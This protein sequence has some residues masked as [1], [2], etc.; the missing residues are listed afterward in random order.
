MSAKSMKV[1]DMTKGNPLRLILTFALPILIGNIFQQVYSIVDTM[2]AGY[3]LGDSAIAAIGA[4]S[5]LY[6][7]II[8]LAW[9]M[10]SGFA[11]VVTRAFGAHDEAEVRK[12]VAGT[13]MLDG[14]VTI[15]LT[16]VSLILL[17]PLMHLMNTPE[18]IFSDAY[19][20]MFIICAGMI[21]TITYNMFASLLRSFGNSVVPLYFLIF[22][23]VMNI[24]LDL[25]FV[26]PM[27]M[28]VAGAAL[29]TVISELLS[30]ILSGAYYFRNYKPMVP[31]KE[32]FRISGELFRELASNGSAMAFMY[33]VVNLGSVFFQGANNKLAETL[34]E[35]IITAHTAARRIIGIMMTPLG[36][37][38]GA[39][40]TYIGQNYGAK[41]MKRVKEGLKD[42]LFIVAGWGV[43]ACAVIYLFG[44]QL[45]RFTTGTTDAE[46][47]K[48]AM[49]SLRI[50]L[51]LYPALGVLLALRTAM[52]AVNIK[53]P[54]VV[55][56][57]IELAMKI[58]AAAWLIPK[59]GFIG[60]CITEPITWVLCAVF[61]IAVYWRKRNGLYKSAH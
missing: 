39:A 47:L 20:Y 37:V 46:V 49:M 41:E 52:Q 30:A 60:T 8:D 28:G 31:G 29:A 17:R 57:S 10:N 58:I 12:A 51:P 59:L 6:A 13:V 21:G 14:A 24:L 23:S 43:F 48:N 3:N 15:A 56:S 27:K 9:G 2:V 35:G 32:D 40:A 19:I 1:T 45:V 61:L 44:S 26:G 55:S 42:E 54:T 18:S 4:T 36:T 34:G 16:V 22:S 25:L 11:L 5:S 33:S 38:T 50:H 7:L 53:T